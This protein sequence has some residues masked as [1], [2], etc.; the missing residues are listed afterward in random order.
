MPKKYILWIDDTWTEYSK[1]WPAIKALRDY[2]TAN[3]TFEPQRI[4]INVV[5]TDK[6]YTTQAVSYMT[7]LRGVMWRDA[8][9]PAEW[10]GALDAV[11]VAIPPIGNINTPTTFA[12]MSVAKGYTIAKYEW[13][14]DGGA[15]WTAG[16]KSYTHTFTDPG[17]YQVV[18]RITDDGGDKDKSKVLDYVVTGAKG[19]KVKTRT[20][21]KAKTM[22]K[23]KAK[24]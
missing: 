15:T 10:T 7:L 8:D 20:K 1:I 13:S 4:V 24:K 21:A 23:A 2:L 9:V 16:D 22:A 6:G 14:I 19:S 5:G 11:F 18:L 3:P 17:K 12:S